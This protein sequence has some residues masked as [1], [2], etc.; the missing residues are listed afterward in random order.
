MSWC[1]LWRVSMLKLILVTATMMSYYPVA[2]SAQTQWQTHT[3]TCTADD[4]RV[5][6][7]PAFHPTASFDVNYFRPEDH[8]YEISTGT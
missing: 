2:V 5:Y 8:L 7:H 4:S 1:D 6:P 3:V